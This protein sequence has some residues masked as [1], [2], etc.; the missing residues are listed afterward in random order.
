MYIGAGREVGMW[1]R[2][3]GCGL[4]QLDGPEV[5][6]FLGGVLYLLQHFES[7]CSGDWTSFGGKK[8]CRVRA[9][10]V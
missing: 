5:D 6:K 7:R 9:N 4:V 8:G 3:D 1:G 10:A 2:R